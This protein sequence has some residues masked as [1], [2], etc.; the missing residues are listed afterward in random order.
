MRIGENWP[1]RL[2]HKLRFAFV[3]QGATI[4]LYMLH[5]PKIGDLYFLDEQMGIWSLGVCLQIGIWRFAVCLRRCG[6]KNH[7]MKLLIWFWSAVAR[8][9]GSTWWVWWNSVGTKEA[10]D[11]RSFSHCIKAVCEGTYPRAQFFLHCIKA[12]CEGTYPWLVLQARQSQ[13]TDLHHGANTRIEHFGSWRAGHWNQSAWSGSKE[14][15]PLRTATHDR[16]AEC[17]PLQKDICHQEACAW[18]RGCTWASAIGIS[19]WPW[20]AFC[21]GRRHHEPYPRP[22]AYSFLHCR[23][24]RQSCDPA[25]VWLLRVSSRLCG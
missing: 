1:S 8:E 20:H 2:C 9:C 13:A 5:P 6:Y 17:Q 16:C 15:Y 14:V 10:R 3:K 21:N 11:E 19:H 22:W 4:F 18:R 23:C 25:G 7:M 24:A 12:D